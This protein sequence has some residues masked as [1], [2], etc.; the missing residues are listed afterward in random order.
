SRYPSG[1]SSKVLS[2]YWPMGMTVWERQR[3][4]EVHRLQYMRVSFL[5]VRDRGRRGDTPPSYLFGGKP[6]L[7]TKAVSIC[8]Q[9]A[10][11]LEAQRV[12][13]RQQDQQLTVRVGEP[14]GQKRR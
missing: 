10:G 13:E 14:M 4:L 2:A 1:I 5:W 8:D 9:G 7:R 3:R 6:Y 12:C 11:T